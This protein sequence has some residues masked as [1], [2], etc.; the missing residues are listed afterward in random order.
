MASELMS[1]I[2]ALFVYSQN[3]NMGFWLCLSWEVCSGHLKFKINL[4]E[5]HAYIL[6]INI[7]IYETRL[8]YLVHVQLAHIIMN[9]FG[10]EQDMGMRLVLFYSTH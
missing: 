7:I 1:S 5:K 6:S 3:S 4:F 8:L 2:I 9:N 10:Q